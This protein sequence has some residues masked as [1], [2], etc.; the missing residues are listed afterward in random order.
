MKVIAIVS[1]GL[2]STVLLY[3]LVSKGYS[4]HALSFDYG[5]RHVREIESA[6]ASCA[7]LDVLHSRIDLTT[8]QDLLASSLTFNAP[9]P[10]GHY[11]AENMKATV[12]PN[13][14]AI[15][16][17][18]AY[19]VAVS[20]GANYVYFGAH[21]GDHAIYPDCRPEFVEMLSATLGEGNE[22]ADPIPMIEAPFLTH[23]KADIVRL[24][25]GLSVP[26]EDT[27]SCYQ[28]LSH[29]C[30]R[31]GTCVERA[32]AFH[33]AGVPDPTVYEDPDYWKQA[34]QQ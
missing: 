3:S 22:W 16:L 20:R 25:A 32:E 4:V 17:S 19:G 34:V 1:G 31:C 12:V 26:F 28:G 15:M 9:V 2:D 23:S 24:G 8:L 11:A 29:H 30:G 18:I 10:E 5:Q 13:R 33:I 6:V 7:K 27:W 14:N 21:A